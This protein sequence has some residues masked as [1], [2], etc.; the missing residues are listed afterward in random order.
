MTSFRPPYRRQCQ[1]LRDSL[2]HPTPAR[3]NQQVH[4]AL[5][6][7][8]IKANC[9]SCW[10]EL[11][12]RSNGHD[13][14]GRHASVCQHMRRPANIKLNETESRKAW[15]LLSDFGGSDWW[16]WARVP[17]HPNRPDSKASKLVTTGVGG[18]GTHC[19]FGRATIP[20]CWGCSQNL[21]PLLSASSKP[22][23]VSST[24]ASP[25]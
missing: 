23:Q 20:P 14:V 13:N 24:Q 10:L 7:D 25:S 15:Q 9:L 6:T 18:L 22:H 19:P 2:V 11:A 21:P 16:E 12:R 5:P 8:Y 4:A 1:L 3:S 17:F